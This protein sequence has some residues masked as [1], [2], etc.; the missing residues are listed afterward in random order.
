MISL[1]PFAALSAAQIEQFEQGAE[2]LLDRTG[3]CVQ[4]DA[5]RAR[6]RAEGARVDGGDGRVRFPKGL[7]RELLGR[8]PPTYT[9]RNA[10]GGRCEIGG[11]A[12][13][14]LFAITNDP[15]IIDYESGQPRHPRLED[16]VRHTMLG[17]QIESVVCMSCMDYPV[18]EC[19]D[20]TSSWRALE[21]HL[22][23]HA[24]H[25]AV[26]AASPEKFEDCLAVAQVLN[27]GEDPAGSRLMTCG[28]A[29]RS[30]LTL[31]AP[32][33]EL[34][35]AACANDFPVVPTICP[36]AGTTAPYSLASTLLLAHAENV[37]M[38]ALTQ[39]VRPG[40]PFQYGLG[41]S[42]SDMRTAHD[43]YYTLDKVLWKVAGAQLAKAHGIPC[44][45]ECGGT[46]SHRGDT[47]AGAEG[48]LFMLAAYASGADLLC[49]LGSCY[50]AN[51]LSAEMM[52]IQ[53][54]WLDAARFLAQG[55][56]T[57]PTRLGLDN[58]AAGGPGGEFL[59]DALTLEF[60]RGGE[61]FDNA[62][63]DYA[64][65]AGAGRS[66]LERAHERVEALLAG[67]ACPVPHDIQEG[68]A[69]HFHDFYC[70]HG[71]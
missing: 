28:V 39:L 47:Q 46:M 40:H 52:V 11:A 53:E 33:G 24:K 29:V 1:N 5:L 13:P 61:F 30:P 15:W 67:Y 55:L 59:T 50:N 63:F 71:L 7:L 51:G 26:L 25:W 43:R 31:T 37:F 56:R 36:M 38:A 68:L 58:L 49:G 62:L 69:R 3:F 8:I 66:M 14:G 44:G 23:H 64:G 48:M 9:I 4:H 57:D 17:Q 34:L 10:A 41:P 60:C 70:Q 27:G 35:L 16:V 20:A 22:R 18:V 65:D 42:V 19:A 21:A 12:E 2:D 45:A 54:A 6:A 32:N